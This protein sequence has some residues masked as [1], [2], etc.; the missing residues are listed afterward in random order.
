MNP[1]Q[2][3]SDLKAIYLAAIKRVDPYT[4]VR[5]R[6]TLD[7]NTLKIHLENQ[8]MR[9]GLDKFENIYV[10]GAGKATAPMARAIEEIL[11]PKLSG[12][13]ISVK[14]GHTDILK[15][16]KII[17][18]G[19]PVP[20]KNSVSAAQQVIDIAAKGKE[21]TLFINLISGGG[22][23]LWA[24][25]GECGGASITLADKQKT[26]E[27]L[28]ACGAGINEINRVR[29]QL[30]GIKGGKLARHMYPGTSVN[31]ILS[32]VVGDD[33]GTIASGP[34]APD[35]TTFTQALGIVKKYE[36]SSRLPAR[37]VK[38]LESGAQQKTDKNEVSDDQIFSKVHNILLGNNLSALNAARH[39][40]ERLGYN[41]L[42]LSSRITGEA[43]EIAKVFSGMARDIALGSLPPQRPAC[44]LAG[45]ETTVAIQ[46]NGKGG[47]NQEMA[48]SFLQ[49]LETSPAGIENIFFLSGATDGN[50]GPTDAAGAFASRTV[51]DA[52][53]KAGMNISEYLARNDSYTYFDAAGH[54]FK[55][56]PT[57]TNVCDLQI[58]IIK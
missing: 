40:A 58:L 44:V 36:L 34:T 9:L 6:V 18:A 21:T 29:K 11:G 26:T 17:E 32:D 16:I 30:S 54:L 53:K 28:L 3:F 5:S 35:L 41:T 12:G 15:K 52:G 33:L 22:S 31:L 10:L 4:M 13:L 45:G 57:N 55:P 39:K 7:S 24:C 23:A 56:G 27:R 1:S 20:D 47:R 19:H 38:M 42:V 50:D 48:L 25:P 14:K 37:V 51:L 2:P 8:D 46:G 49:E 43:R